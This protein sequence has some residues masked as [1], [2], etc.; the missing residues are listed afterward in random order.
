L[1][2]GADSSMLGPVCRRSGMKPGLILVDIQND[3]FSDG[4]MPL[5]GMERAAENAARVL[6]EFR[7]ANAPVFHVRHLSVRAG[8]AFFLPQTPGAET[9]E[10]V[11][12]LASEKVFEKH[13]PNSFRD[14]RLL[15]C[16]KESA[17]EQVV[18]CGAM[19]HMC[20]DATTR[21][22]FDLGFRCVLID[23]ACAT[24]DLTWRGRAVA[25]RDVHAAFMGALSGTYA[26]LVKAG[27]FRL[28]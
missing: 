6:S 4:K 5:A 11:R 24:R 19:S 9:H 17:L 23:D 18:I 20:I 25:A 15:E 28:A 12:P 21:A 1:T 10:S 16:L 27:D 8:A 26:E 22:A 14:T 3:Y 7:S 2:S 13:F